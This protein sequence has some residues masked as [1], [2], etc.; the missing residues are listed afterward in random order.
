MSSEGIIV[1]LVILLVIFISC[2][3]ILYF[4]IREEKKYK[5]TNKKIMDNIADSTSKFINNGI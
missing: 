1:L 3:F 2:E 4:K 5:S